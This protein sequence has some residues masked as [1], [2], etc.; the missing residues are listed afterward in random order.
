V[1]YLELI[2]TRRHR[3][4]PSTFRLIRDNGNA[5]YNCINARGYEEC[6]GD[7]LVA[8]GMAEDIRDALFEYQV[9][10][11]NASAVIVPLKLNPSTDEPATGD[12]RPRV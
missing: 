11:D 2:P 7:I 10:G 3:L 12:V 5:L 1:G 6:P 9:G 8:S 4:S